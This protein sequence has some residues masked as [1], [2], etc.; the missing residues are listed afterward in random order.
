MA[1]KDYKTM[2][3]EL[4]WPGSSKREMNSGKLWFVLPYPL[5]LLDAEI[6]TWEKRTQFFCFA[7][8]FLPIKWLG[9]VKTLKKKSLLNMNAQHVPS[10]QTIGLC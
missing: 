9:I 8:L 7:T 6:G 5:Y 3:P 4:S 1:D 2:F 10:D